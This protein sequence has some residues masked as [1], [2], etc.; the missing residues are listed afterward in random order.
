MGVGGAVAGA[1]GSAASSGI[2]SSLTSLFGPDSPLMNILGSEGMKNLITGGLGLKNGLEMG[3][4]LDFQKNLAVK[5]DARTEQIFDRD[6]EKDELR[7]KAFDGASDI[8][9]F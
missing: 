6:M 5:A 3:D 4:M 9:G 7:S 2:M 8:L 1:A